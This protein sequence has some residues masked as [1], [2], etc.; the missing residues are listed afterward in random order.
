MPFA[1]DRGQMW[2]N[3]EVNSLGL[4]LTSDKKRSLP[5]RVDTYSVGTTTAASPVKST[6]C[7]LETLSVWS[8]V[9]VRA[10]PESP[11]HWALSE[12]LKPLK[13]GRFFSSTHL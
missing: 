12:E 5:L 13:S 11:R 8:A 6:M 7:P 3:I 4:L 9:P 2:G 10:K 1:F